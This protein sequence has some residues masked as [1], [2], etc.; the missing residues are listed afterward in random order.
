M[1]EHITQPDLSRYS[2]ISPVSVGSKCGIDVVEEKE[3]IERTESL[4]YIQLLSR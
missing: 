1:N 3:V 2:R 4:I